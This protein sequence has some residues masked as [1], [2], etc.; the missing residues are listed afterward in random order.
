MNIRSK[1]YGT[2]IIPDALMEKSVKLGYDE[3]ATFFLGRDLGRFIMF[4]A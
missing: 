3:E 1:S 2:L 4:G